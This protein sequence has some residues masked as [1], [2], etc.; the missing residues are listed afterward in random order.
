MTQ[1]VL[2]HCNFLEPGSVGAS[3]LGLPSLVVL[4]G[5]VDEQMFVLTMDGSLCEDAVIQ[6]VFLFSLL[7]TLHEVTRASVVDTRRCCTKNL[8]DI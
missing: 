5:A 7:Q 8:T 2:C 4:S 3:T 1:P 6:V